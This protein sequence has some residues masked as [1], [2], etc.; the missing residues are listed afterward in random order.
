MQS[1]KSQVQ[2]NFENVA[3]V[4]AKVAVVWIP[5]RDMCDRGRAEVLRADHQEDPFGC[6][7][8]LA[9]LSP[10][11]RAKADA[12]IR[13]QEEI[14]DLRGSLEYFSTCVNTREA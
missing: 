11:Q 4:G 3:L 6:E 14:D 13:D 10:I 2:E 5:A 12:F 8:G 9:G 7:K 1:F